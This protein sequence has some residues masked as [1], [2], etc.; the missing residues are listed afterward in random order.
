MKAIGLAAASNAST[1]VSTASERRSLSGDVSA[2]DDEGVEIVCGDPVDG[3]VNGHWPV[4][5]L[6]GYR[7]VI[8]ARHGHVTSPSRGRFRST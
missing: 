7:L 3:G 6:A 8:E 1:R 5:L 2:R 4:A